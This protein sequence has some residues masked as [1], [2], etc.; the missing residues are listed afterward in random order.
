MTARILLASTLVLSFGCDESDGDTGN[1]SA[2]TGNDSAETGS[3]SAETGASGSAVCSCDEKEIYGRCQQATRKEGLSVDIAP[4]CGPVSAACEASGGT[5]AEAPCPTADSVGSC[6]DDN[7]TAEDQ[8]LPVTKTTV[9]Y[10][11]GPMPWDA[12]SAEATCDP[13]DEVFM[14]AG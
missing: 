3:D 11:A 13:D 2:E 7:E 5:Y 1:D 8:E 10:A 12:A 14:P 6:F 9:Y 4:Y